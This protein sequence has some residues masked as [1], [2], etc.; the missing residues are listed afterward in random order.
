MDARRYDRNADQL[1]QIFWHFTRKQREYRNQPAPR[2]DRMLELLEEALRIND[3][4]GI[5]SQKG[6]IWWE[7]TTRHPL[8]SLHSK[9]NPPSEAI[10]TGGLSWWKASWTIIGLINRTNHMVHGMNP[11]T[12]ICLCTKCT[13]VGCKWASNYM[14]MTRGMKND[15][16]QHWH[17]HLYS[18][19]TSFLHRRPSYTCA[20][21]RFQDQSIM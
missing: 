14:E 11:H 13:F 10:W 3:E 8:K 15:N 19:P 21:K 6:L 16:A 2:I 7:I 5:L 9:K 17:P 1:S 12:L 20:G 4:L 18:V